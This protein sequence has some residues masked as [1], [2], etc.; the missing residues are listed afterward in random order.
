[1]TRHNIGFLT[2]DAL[3]ARHDIEM[4]RN[5][6]EAY[7]GEG[8]IEG[9][10]VMLIKP[11][12]YMNHSGIAV[13]E[14]V[15]YY[16]AEPEELLL[17]YDD[18]DLEAGDIRIRAGGSA[19]THNGMRSV[20]YQLG[21]DT[22]PRIRVGIGKA[23]HDMVHHVLSMPEGEEWEKLKA[24][25]LGAADAAELIATGRL[26]EAQARFNR[27][28]AKKPKAAEADGGRETAGGQEGEAQA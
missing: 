4:R 18:A 27:R 8:Y 15:R 7:F 28:K 9:K 14:F 24:A 20:I 22:F 3:G 13:R 10:K 19:G 6:F 1:M 11:D 25:M 17:I 2:L 21:F 26:Q 23:P 12:T 5:R 16:K